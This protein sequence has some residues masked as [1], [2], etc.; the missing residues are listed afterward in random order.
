MP[1]VEWHI[2]L[3]ESVL[4]EFES[5]SDQDEQDKMAIAIMRWLSGDDA[6]ELLAFFASS[7]TGRRILKDIRRAVA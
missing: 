1:R 4:A 3:Y 6:E 5:I 7:L 2:S